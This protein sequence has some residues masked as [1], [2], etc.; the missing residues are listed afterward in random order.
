M[1]VEPEVTESKVTAKVD[2]SASARSTIRRQRTVRYSPLIRNRPT[3]LRSQ[4]IGNARDVDR[5]YLLEGI[6][7]ENAAMPSPRVVEDELVDVEVEANLAHA[8]ASQRRRIESGR[9]LLRD[10]LSYER[11]GGH[12]RP[13]Y[14]HYHP[15]PHPHHP[16]HTRV[17]TQ[18]FANS[19]H[20]GFT[21]EGL[22]YYSDS[23]SGSTIANVDGSSPQPVATEVR[24]PPPAYMPTPPHTSGDTSNRPTS[25]T[26]TPVET[27]SFTPQFAPAH[28]YT[29][30]AE[31]AFRQY[32]PR[33]NLDVPTDQDLDSLPPLRRMTSRDPSHYSSQRISLGSD[34]IDGLGDRRRSFS[35]EDDSWETLL[36]TIAPDE[37]LPSVHT[38]FTSAT[39]SASSL[40]SNSASSYG[41]LVTAPSS[42]T[43]MLDVYPTICDNTDFDD[44]DSDDMEYA[45]MERQFLDTSED[46]ASTAAGLRH[47]VRMRALEFD[48]AEQLA[49][50]RRIFE[51]EEELRQAQTNLD[52]LQGQLRQEWWPASRRE[53]GI[54]AR[55]GR[56]RL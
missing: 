11:P 19:R 8:E 36:T 31:A 35:P 37:R 50:Q 56:E 44:S 6:R 52:R 22:P 48:R 53:Q 32:A 47:R 25:S 40:S 41:T 15:R 13:H 42:T 27:A 17:A 18:A 5:R 24:S 9:A 16:H 55:T 29:E 10:A 26:T 39:A 7:R 38:S 1:F 14:H 34:A 33:Q 45:A 28:R 23:R 49:R 4:S 54:G 12:M 46:D 20:L 2:P 3:S 30:T 43:D 51:C 21:D